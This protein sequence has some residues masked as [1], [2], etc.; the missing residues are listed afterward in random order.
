MGCGMSDGRFD[1][2]TVRAVIVKNEGHRDERGSPD[3]NKQDRRFYSAQAYLWTEQGRAKRYHTATPY[4]IA[5]DICKRL[6][7]GC[8]MFMELEGYVENYTFIPK[9]KHK[10]ADTERR[11]KAFKTGMINSYSHMRFALKKDGSG[12]L[13]DSVARLITCRPLL[14]TPITVLVQA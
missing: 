11:L 4:Q 9:P 6:A 7:T 14:I 13:M 5:D 1:Y 12:Y 8:E 3:Y 2:E 10:D